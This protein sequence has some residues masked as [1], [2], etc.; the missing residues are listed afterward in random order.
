MNSRGAN[1]KSEIKIDLKIDQEEV[2][3]I[4]GLFTYEK[5]SKKLFLRMKRQFPVY[6]LDS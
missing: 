5:G 4:M 2:N 6:Y 1:E 3:K